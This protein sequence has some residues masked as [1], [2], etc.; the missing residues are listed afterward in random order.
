MTSVTVDSWLMHLAARLLAVGLSLCW[1]SNCVTA[2][3]PELPAPA[4]LPNSPDWRW[5][6]IE[7]TLRLIAQQRAEPIN[8]L[9]GIDTRVPIQ[10]ARIP[11]N[12]A[13]AP[14]MLPVAPAD[15]RNLPIQVIEI[16][17]GQQRIFVRVAEPA[18]PEGAN[19]WITSILRTRDTERV[20]VQCEE[21]LNTHIERIDRQCNLSLDQ[22]R[23][24]Q[25]GGLGDISRFLSECEEVVS[26]ATRPEATDDEKRALYVQARQLR[27][28]YL[29][30]LH[31]SG[32]LFNKMLKSQLTAR[33]LDDVGP[34][35]QP[36]MPEVRV[37]PAEHLFR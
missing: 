21:Q 7:D 33:Q 34:I 4:Q 35:L 11:L 18:T 28:L 1:C 29:T 12:I 20:R 16:R 23:K 24:L 9:Q 14:V 5:R 32:S 37:L 19:A 30:G 2:D 15:V 27:S 13:P 26:Q 10:P 3:E 8:P 17:G 22:I 31:Q 6:G 36:A 25:L